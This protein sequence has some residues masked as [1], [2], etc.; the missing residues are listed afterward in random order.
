MRMFEFREM[1]GYEEVPD[2]IVLAASILEA[3]GKK[4]CVDFGFFNAVEQAEEVLT[5]E[6]ALA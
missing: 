4:F 1:F 3:R 2:S 6:A 5:R